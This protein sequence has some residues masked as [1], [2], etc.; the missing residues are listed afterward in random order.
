MRC[1]PDV[2]HKFLTSSLNGY[3]VISD[4]TNSDTYHIPSALT[5]TDLR[6][7]PVIF[8]K[9]KKHVALI[10]LTIP[11]QTNLKKA[12]QRKLAKYLELAEDIERKGFDVDLI[13]V[14]VGS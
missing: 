13:I 11:F 1:C 5:F 7:D 4:L 10:E 14:E 8:N 2:I 9:A 6:P 12:Q 3:S